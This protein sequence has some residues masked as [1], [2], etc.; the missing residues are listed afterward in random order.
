MPGHRNIS[1]R[2]YGKSKDGNLSLLAAKDSTRRKFYYSRNVTPC[3]S[4][5]VKRFLLSIGVSCIS[6]F[7]VL[8]QK[9]QSKEGSGSVDGSQESRSDPVIQDQ[10]SSTAFRFCINAGD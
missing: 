6:S 2:L 10:Q 1:R 8:R 7:P 3:V 5:N 4:E 9:K